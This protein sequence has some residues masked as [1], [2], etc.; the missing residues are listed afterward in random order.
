[1]R[2]QGGQPIMTKRARSSGASATT[3]ER[4]AAEVKALAR[5]YAPAAVAE[6]GRLAI[7]AESETARLAAIKEI[8]ERAYGRAPLAAAEGAKSLLQYVLVDD[9]Y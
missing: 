9:G 3:P 7:E 4:Q 5:D 6:L 2:E 1:M 8:L